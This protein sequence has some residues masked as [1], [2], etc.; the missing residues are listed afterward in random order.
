MRFRGV[1]ENQEEEIST[2]LLK[3]LADWLG[4][5]EDELLLDIEKIFRIKVNK[6]RNKKG[7]GD[8]LVFLNSRLL[9]EKIL[10]KNRTDP[11]CIEGKVIEIMKEIPTRL[12]KRRDNSRFLTSALKKNK[13]LFRWE[14]PEGLTFTYKE[15]RRT[16][17]SVEETRI[18][19]RKYWEELGGERLQE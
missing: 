4:V 17:R 14:F 2:K 7:P 3:E 8:C 18:F 13:I 15:R 9:R 5:E 11:L 16:L 10:L 6:S 19:W 12:L 1:K